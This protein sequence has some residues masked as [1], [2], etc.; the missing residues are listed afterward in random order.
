VVREDGTWFIVWAGEYW[1]GE[2]DSCVMTDKQWAWVRGVM[3]RFQV[4]CPDDGD[5]DFK[6]SI[7]AALK[8][9]FADND[10]PA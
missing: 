7:H 1:G 9:A 10:P 2:F 4:R 3:M 8:F 5:E 6:G